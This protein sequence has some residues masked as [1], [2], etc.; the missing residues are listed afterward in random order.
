VAAEETGRGQAA[1]QS[2]PVWAREKPRRRPALSRDAIVDAA[3]QIAD[4]EGLDAVS[5]RRVASNLGVRP[6]SL[7]TYI[8]RKEDLIILMRDKA[9][10]EVVLDTELPN[11]WREAVT[12]I[13]RRTREVM[14]RH[15]WIVDTNAHGAGLSPNALRH[16]EESLTA[17]RYL[18][19]SPRD[20]VDVLTAIDKF[21]LGHATFEIADRVGTAARR[22]ARP[23]FESLLASGEFPA[24][25]RLL[26][27]EAA[28]A[29]AEPQ[30]ER[31]F[32]RGLAWLLDGIEAG[33]K[34]P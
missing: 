26:S 12:A 24:L 4:A 15:P 14:L 2:V 9:N 8:D 21:T 20:A 19:L 33:I 30:Y 5:I 7:Y 27:D 32:E 31:Q 29:V 11:G 25:A 23:Y 13:A 18:H 1:D 22:S 3:L 34:A 16:L 17:L 28:G 6:M 10:G